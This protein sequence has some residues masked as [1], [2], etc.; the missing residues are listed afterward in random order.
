MSALSVNAQVAAA[1]VYVQE[2][3]SLEKIE[4]EHPELASGVKRIRRDEKKNAASRGS[5][6]KKPVSSRPP[7]FS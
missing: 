2:G 3:H 4:K 5:G 1:T 7:R 6:P